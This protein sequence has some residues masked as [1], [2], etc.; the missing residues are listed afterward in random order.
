MLWIGVHRIKSG[1][2][3]NW[4]HLK[5]VAHNECWNLSIITD[6][7]L[8]PDKVTLGISSMTS[9]VFLFLPSQITLKDAYEYYNNHDVITA[10]IST[11]PQTISVRCLT[12][13][14]LQHLI[15]TPAPY[16]F[17]ALTTSPSLPISLISFWPRSLFWFNIIVNSRPSLSL[18]VL[19]N[20]HI[21]SLLVYTCHPN[22]Y[23]IKL[24]VYH[25]S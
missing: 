2:Y 10:Y 6:T 21:H 22:L 23:S 14:S 3:Y 7:L 24:R 25:F 17:P 11:W 16:L 18:I 19:Q 4:A 13:T 20:I 15:I 12:P 9:I 5:E 1:I 8:F